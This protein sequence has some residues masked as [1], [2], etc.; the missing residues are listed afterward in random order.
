MTKK[1]DIIF[2]NRVI[3]RQYEKNDCAA[4][5]SPRYEQKKKSRPTNYISTSTKSRFVIFRH[6]SCCYS[7]SVET[8]LNYFITA[9]VETTRS[10]SVCLLKGAGR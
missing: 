9:E 1:R 7:R 3:L 2:A 6:E 10:S 5:R 8:T 4:K